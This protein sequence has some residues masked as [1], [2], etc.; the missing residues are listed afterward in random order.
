MGDKQSQKSGDSSQNIQA[1]RDITIDGLSYS[2][3]R[4]V[5]MDVYKANFL[6]LRDEAAAIAYE[7]AERFVESFLQKMAQEG[8][9]EIP[10]GKNPDFQAAF[11]Q[12]HKEYA[13]TGDQD[14]GD[15]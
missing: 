8:Q 13:R 11:Y 1:G 2:E 6:E 4:Q 9:K 7:R 12:A 15:L 14:L 3:T 5:A 10:E